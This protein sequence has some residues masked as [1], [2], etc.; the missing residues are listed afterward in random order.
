MTTSPFVSLANSGPAAGRSST[1]TEPLHAFLDHDV[2]ERQAVH[3]GIALDLA[4]LHVEAFALVGLSGRR[5][6]AVSVDRHLAPLS[7]CQLVSP[8]AHS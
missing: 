3:E 5:D 8:Y 2:V 4:P 7:A 6:P 1:G